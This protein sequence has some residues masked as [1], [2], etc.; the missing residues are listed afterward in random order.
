MTDDKVKRWVELQKRLRKRVLRVR[1]QRKLEFGNP[2]TMWRLVGRAVR[3]DKRRPLGLPQGVPVGT[4][5]VVTDISY[6]SGPI[7]PKPFW[8]LHITFFT[9]ER[10]KTDESAGKTVKIDTRGKPKVSW[11]PIYH[12]GVHNSRKL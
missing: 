8:V 2:R 5:G 6:Q 3:Y 7:K 12:A 9:L 10:S 11:P 1:K 4:I